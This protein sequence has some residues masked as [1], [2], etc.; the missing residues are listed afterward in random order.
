MGMLTSSLLPVFGNSSWITP[1]TITLPRTVKHRCLAEKTCCRIT[2]RTY[3]TGLKW[4]ITILFTYC[5]YLNCYII[6]I[7]CY[8]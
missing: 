5:Q 6:F 2:T 1:R 8:Y 7:C 4:A 3:L